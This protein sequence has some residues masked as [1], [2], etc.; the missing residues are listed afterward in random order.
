MQA[1]GGFSR[2]KQP[3]HIRH[4]RIAIHADAAHHVMRGGPDFHRLLGNVNIGQLLELV[5]HAGQF[6]LNVRGGFRDVLPDPGDV[7]IDAAVRASAAA[8]DFAIDATR[9]MIAR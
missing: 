9:H 4:L 5:V 8:L 3:G 6:A 1:R 2:G 7:E